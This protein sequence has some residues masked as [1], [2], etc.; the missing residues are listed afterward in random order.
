MEIG[1]YLWRLKQKG[2]GMSEEIALKLIEQ[3]E[4]IDFTLAIIAG[5]LGALILIFAIKR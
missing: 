5:I 4:K 3:L 2:G 1:K